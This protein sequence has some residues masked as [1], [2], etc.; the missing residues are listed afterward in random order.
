MDRRHMLG[1]VAAGVASLGLVNGKALEAKA[2]DKDAHEGH[3]AGHLQKCMETCA[4]CMNVCN[5]TVHSCYE[6]SLHG[7]AKLLDAM[8]LAMDCQEFCGTS[9]K[10]IGRASPLMNTGCK[11]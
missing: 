8:H 4:N 3:H 7:S 11:A 5:M 1:T 6:K 2:D 9:A 10:L